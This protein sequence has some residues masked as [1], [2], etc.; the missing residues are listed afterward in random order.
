MNKKYYGHPKFY[1]FLK[2]EGELHNR[3]NHDYTFGGDPLG[4][5]NRVSA[6]KKLYPKMDWANSTGVAIGYLL[7]QLDAALWML[8]MGHKAKAEGQH[9][10][11]QDISVYSKIIDILIINKRRKK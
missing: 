2:E 10:R 1:K 3:K 4:N 9:E 11:W 8:S 6:I 5:F 7:K